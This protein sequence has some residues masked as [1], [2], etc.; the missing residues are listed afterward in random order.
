VW[1][2]GVAVGLAATVV[3]SL[4]SSGPAGAAPQTDSIPLSTIGTAP[5]TRSGPLPNQV[6]WSVDR[7]TPHPTQ[8]Y[9][10]FAPNTQTWTFDRPV[11]LRFSV[12]GLTGVPGECMQVPVGSVVESLAPSHTYDPATRTLCPIA[13]VDSADTIFTLGPATSMTLV[14]VGRPE[15]GRGPGFIE[16]TYDL[17]EPTISIPSAGATYVVGQPV[18]AN[19]GCT[20][21]SGAVSTVSGPVANGAPVDTTVT[22]TYTFTVTCTDEFGATSTVTNSYS[23]VPGAVANDDDVVTEADSP[24][25]FDPLANDAPPTGGTLDPTTVVLIDGGNPVT[26]LTNADGTYVVD[27]VRGAI[28]FTPAPGFTG[29]S[30]PVQYRVTDSFGVQTTASITVTVAGG[31]TTTSPT[32]TTT[33]PTDPCASTTTTTTSST[34]TSPSSTSSTTTSS[35][36]TSST[37][38]PSPTESAATTSSSTT[39]SSSTFGASPANSGPSGFARARAQVPD[40]CVSTTTVARTT[41]V[42]TSGGVAT[43]GRGS[44]AGAL[45]VTG[46]QPVGPL[47]VVAILLVLIGAALVIAIRPRQ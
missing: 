17:P 24:V 43:G 15:A 26:T 4:S 12:R 28:T 1:R 23:V 5:P 29:P 38:I 22:G 37:T 25:T 9:V 8:G 18:P 42:V 7:G 44:S 31:T 2:C 40:P 14:A 35:T 13:N 39:S 27:P 46:Q 20:G 10:I 21:G 6:G 33:A 30:T 11:S 32:S 16:V 3:G 41:P 45:P 19:Y 34:T 47:A 36:S